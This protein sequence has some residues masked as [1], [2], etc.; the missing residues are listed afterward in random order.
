MI[1]FDSRWQ[2]KAM[3]YKIDFPR[4]MFSL[5]LQ[6]L[7]GIFLRAEKCPEWKMTLTIYLNVF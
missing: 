1:Q 2:I 7:L 6:L 3:Q 4:G 5:E